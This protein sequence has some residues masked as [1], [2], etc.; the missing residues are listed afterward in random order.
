MYTREDISR[1]KQAFWTAFGRYMQP[2]LSAEGM[3]V[4]WLNY[5][6]GVGGIHFK[7]DVERDH[8]VIMILLSHSD[9]MVKHSFEN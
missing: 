6:T 1:Q 2:V 8:A 9:S 7:M 3:P 4:S 5:K